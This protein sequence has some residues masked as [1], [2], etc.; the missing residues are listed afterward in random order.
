LNEDR[1]PS[2]RRLSEWPPFIVLL[3]KRSMADVRQGDCWYCES[4]IEFGERGCGWS[5]SVGKP[6]SRG[7]G[8]I[9]DQS[10]NGPRRHLSV[11]QLVLEDLLK[12]SMQGD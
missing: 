6:T 1:P 10:R 8:R 2:A 9:S 4:M 12:I 11:T 3:E 5:F 7:R